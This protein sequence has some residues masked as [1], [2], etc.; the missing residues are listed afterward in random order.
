MVFGPLEFDSDPEVAALPE[1]IRVNSPESNLARQLSIF[2]GIQCFSNP[3]SEN[4]LVFAGTLYSRLVVIKL[5]L[6]CN[7]L[8]YIH[9]FILPCDSFV[10]SY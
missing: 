3:D 7:F 1:D 6:H 5:P 9:S 4:G 8:V 2:Q 10:R